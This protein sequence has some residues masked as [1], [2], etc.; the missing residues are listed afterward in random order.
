[1][2]LYSEAVHA[3]RQSSRGFIF[4]SRH[5]RKIQCVRMK[6]V[7]EICSIEYLRNAAMKYQ[8]FCYRGSL[9]PQGDAHT[10]NGDPEFAG[11]IRNVSVV[12]AYLNDQVLRSRHRVVTQ[13]GRIG[14]NQLRNDMD[15]EYLG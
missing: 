14:R 13:V 11:V 4:A 8:W 1:Q 10:F 6:V 5:S 9:R 7:K 2:H 15:R 12:G 3:F